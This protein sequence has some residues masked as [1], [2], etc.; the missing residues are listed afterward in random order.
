[1][2][3]SGGTHSTLRPSCGFDREFIAPR[4]DNASMARATHTCTCG[5]V[6]QYK[7]D[8]EK[9]RGGIVAAW[10]CKEC[11]TPVP[12]MVAEKLKHQHPS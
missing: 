10:K 12:G 7:Q 1:M 3:V 5:A 4:D 9:E 2:L 6:L 11:G 8:L